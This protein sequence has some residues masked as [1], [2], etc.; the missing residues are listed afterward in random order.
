MAI[1][2]RPSNSE[3]C[4][5]SPQ[6]PASLPIKAVKV[7]CRKSQIRAAACLGVLKTTQQVLKNLFL[8]K[9]LNI[10][11]C[12]FH[13]PGVV[14]IGHQEEPLQQVGCVTGRLSLKALTARTDWQFMQIPISLLGLSMLQRHH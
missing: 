10:V 2:L 1:A 12:A 9:W 13:F 6:P 14:R 3:I 8:V 7:I 5:M 11:P 4:F